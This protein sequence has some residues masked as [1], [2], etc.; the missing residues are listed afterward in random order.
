MSL[1]SLSTCYGYSVHVEIIYPFFKGCFY[2]LLWILIVVGDLLLVFWLKRE[3]SASSLFMTWLLAFNLSF[4][5]FFGIK[6]LWWYFWDQHSLWAYFM[7]SKYYGAKHEGVV[8]FYDSFSPLK[9]CLLFI[10]CIVEPKCFGLLDLAFLFLYMTAGFVLAFYLRLIL[11]LF[12]W[13]MFLFIGK[14]L[15][16]IRICFKMCYP[17]LS[18]GRF[19]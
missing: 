10:H 6:N 4:H 14:V 3:V 15:F 17:P 11:L 16:E 12:L 13:C 18:L 7:K 19:C 1:Y 2:L 8:Q 9:R 5:G